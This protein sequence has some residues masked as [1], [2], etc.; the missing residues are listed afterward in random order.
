MNFK[1][2][3]LITLSFLLLSAGCMALD[4]EQEETPPEMVF[5]RSSDHEGGS[6]CSSCSGE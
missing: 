1:Y 2:N 4:K 3:L 6:G 5:E